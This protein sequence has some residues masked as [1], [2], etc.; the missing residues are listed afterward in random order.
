M[1]ALDSPQWSVLPTSRPTPPAPRRIAPFLVPLALVVL[2]WIF[3]AHTLA[4][5]VLVVAT[6]ITV[7][8]TTSPRAQARFDRGA[9]WIAHHV[10]NIL[11]VVLL[12][13]VQLLI[14]TPV[15]LIAR[16][17]RSDPMD[18]RGTKLVESRWLRRRANERSLPSRQYGDERYRQAAAG[19][20]GAIGTPRWIRGVVGG[21]ALLLL[22]D[23]VVGSLLARLDRDDSE[24]IDGP[25]FGFDPVAQEALA[26]QPGAGELMSQLEGAG[27]GNSDPFIGWRFGAGVITK[28][29]FVNVV[30]GA[31]ESRASALDGPAR[32]V[33]F[34]GG[35]TLYGSGQSDEATIPSAIVALF[36]AQGIAIN[37]TNF[38]HPAY[39][40]WQQVQLLEAELSAGTRTA[41]DVVVF[42]DG[43][44][45]LTLQTQF[46]VHDEPTHLFFGVANP[47]TTS[48]PTV[49]QTVRSWWADH[50]AA[51]VAAGRVR[52]VFD[53]EP[54]IQVADIEAAPIDSID[55]IAAGNAAA[56]IHRRGVDHV[57]AL[58]R[59]YGFDTRFFWQPYL[60]TK[61]PLTPAEQ[62]LVGLPGYDT[63]V[64]FPMTAQVRSQLSAP[65]IDLSDALDGE[66]SSVFWDFVH[67]NERG[68]ALVAD[69]MLADLEEALS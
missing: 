7:V 31:R 53:D 43:F 54:T 17:T 48:S 19:G 3:G 40:Q 68:A 52:D 45:D 63:D 26:N 41:P 61:D 55:P 32:E 27:L 22:A 38:G 67:T 64:W 13:F 15:A 35:S 6:T 34:F 23:V 33:W 29:E 8:T 69:A 9:A 10:G 66:T 16:L 39:A 25:I 21:L 47:A 20:S 11:T 60:Y 4:V 2:L 28:S 59:A 5:I 51:A 36:D 18:P 1:A 37:A 46:G 44:N 30:D 12:G 58:G 49:A 14:F 57:V 65:I 56:A 42:Y 24:T 50:S 62:D